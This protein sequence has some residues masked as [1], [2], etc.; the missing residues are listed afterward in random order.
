MLYRQSCS[1]PRPPPQIIKLKRLIPQRLSKNTAAC[2]TH[3]TCVGPPSPSQA[4]LSPARKTKLPRP[5]QQRPQPASHAATN[6]PF[7]NVPH[8]LKEPY[9]LPSIK[10]LLRQPSYEPRDGT[11]GRFTASLHCK[12]IQEAMQA[13]AD[14]LT[15]KFAS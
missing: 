5:K 13:A 10:P 11:Q 8:V 15:Y 2:P 1:T 7:C 4:K 12:A 6:C 3:L 9:S 14:T